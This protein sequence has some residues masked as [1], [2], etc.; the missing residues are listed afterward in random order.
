ML[1]FIQI[2]KDCCW[3]FLIVVVFYLIYIFYLVIII[4]ISY[5]SCFFLFYLI[6]WSVF[7]K[8]GSF[9]WCIES[10]MDDVIFYL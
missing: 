8:K 6:Y 1:W 3:N 7:V 4:S 10:L 5:C 9:K 2:L